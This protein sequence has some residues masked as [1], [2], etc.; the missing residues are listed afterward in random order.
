MKTF[1]VQ[2]CQTDLGG[3]PRDSRCMTSNIPKVSILLPTL[4]PSS[5]SVI[6]RKQCEY[7]EIAIMARPLAQP[8]CKNG[9]R[10]FNSDGNVMECSFGNSNCP[11]G[12][13]C[14]FSS[15]GQAVCCGDS[16]SIR[17]PAGSSAFEYGGRPLACP[18]GSTKCPNGFACVAS[19]NPQYH[20]CCTTG[21]FMTQPQLPQPQ[22]LRG[23]A[24][25]DPAMN[26]RQFCSPLRDTCPIGYQC[27]ES[28]YPGQYICCTQGD[29]SEQFKGYCPPNQIPYVSR[30]GFPPTCHM[31]LNPCP[32]TAPYVC[33]YSA[34]KQDSYCC[35]PM[36]T[37]GPSLPDPSLSA[38]P[39]RRL[40]GEIP[41]I[42]TVPPSN[43]YA[44]M[45]QTFPGGPIAP[46]MGPI[47]PPSLTA[48]MNLNGNGNNL[49]PMSGMNMNL[50][51]N[52]N[53][54]NYNN[55]GYGLTNQNLNGFTNNQ[56]A[57][58]VPMGGVPSSMAS[59][60]IDRVLGQLSGQSFNS[61]N[62]P[63]FANNANSNQ[64]GAGQIFGGQWSNPD[65]H[66]FTGCPI[67]SRA[68]VRSDPQRCD[69]S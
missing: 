16:E 37:T 56:P 26:Q 60:V 2:I 47:L 44:G 63:Y 24:F 27:M 38:S 32:T 36:D 40:P 14:E 62:N 25:V 66:A 33:I 8:K 10:P 43:P 23:S 31:Q 30:E 48:N 64:P 42:P 7:S 69:M 21:N 39:M 46:G 15:T 68:L 28:D 3:C 53:N 49:R 58:G 18:P 57:I 19:M 65:H 11:A 52:G 55:N 41:S 9:D 12:Y 4:W 59:Q 61:G 51:G 34:M 5:Y 50:N 67:G 6:W 54:F 1:E 35:A 22:C 29:L 17:C 20:L 45:S 13:K